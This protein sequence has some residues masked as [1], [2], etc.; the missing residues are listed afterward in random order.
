MQFE[1]QVRSIL[2]HAWAE[3]EHD[4]GYKSAV[5]LPG[6]VKRRFARVSSL[7]E[8]ADSE[9]SAIRQHLNNYEEA[10]PG[11]I[12]SG[13]EQRSLDF[14]TLKLLV[15]SDPDI[16]LL[17]AA[18]VEGASGA[19]DPLDLEGLSNEVDRLKFLGVDTVG[20]LQR[21]SKEHREDVRNFA[22]YW[23]YGDL[24]NVG[25]GIGFFY[26]CY[27]LIWVSKNRDLAISYLDEFNIDE[28][29]DRNRIAGQILDF[30]PGRR[31]ED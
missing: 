20:K 22:A 27:V 19:L 21:L 13:S 15:S 23:A 2:Q 9:F 12:E 24:D 10:L 26:L 31:I 3:I 1:I 5:G 4:L 30:A 17:D 25:V 28:E 14:P 29:S 7:L 18:V 11:L 6:D 8:L 16:S